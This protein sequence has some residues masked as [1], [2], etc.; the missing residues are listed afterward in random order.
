MIIELT[1]K[2]RYT[3]YLERKKARGLDTEAVP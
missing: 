1:Y 2:Y 3:T